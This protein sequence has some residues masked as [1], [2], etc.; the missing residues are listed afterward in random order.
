MRIL[1]LI[2]DAFGG[3]GGIA[4][5]NRDLIT[6]LCCHPDC[7]EVVAI[8][9]FMPNP[10]EPLPQKLAYITSG[11]D[12]TFKYIAA[13]L[14]VLRRNAQFDLILCG[15]INLLALAFLARA[16]K[17]VPILLVIHG[18]DA[19]KPTKKPLLDY[20]AGQV[21]AFISVSELTQQRFLGWAKLASDRGFILPNTVDLSRF[22]PGLKNPALLERYNLANKTVLMTLG[23]LASKIRRKGF[24]EV[25][26]LLPELT[27]Q[28]PDIKYLIVGDGGDR[29][30]LEEKAKSLQVEDHV[31]FAGLIPESEKVDH[32]YLADAYVMPSRGEGFGIVFLEAM[33]CGIPVVASKTDGG[34][35]ALRDGK[36]GILVNPTDLEEVKAGILRALNSPKGEVPEGLDYFSYSNFEQRCHQIVTQVLRNRKQY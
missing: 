16:W 19:W 1:V 33:A 17:Q 11:L 9:R 29:L 25:L 20:L 23:R 5:F 4:K 26:E 36:L 15:H 24:D 35:E 6:A 18:V 32:Y 14:Q 3:H 22:T 28:L 8:P 30:R 12:G 10:A 13:V 7:T 34:R 21:D 2:T 27:Q 31:I